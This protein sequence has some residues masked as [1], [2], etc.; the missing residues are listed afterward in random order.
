MATEGPF[1]HEQKRFTLRHLRDLGFGKTSYEDMML[2]EI[3]ELLG[4]ISAAAEA[5][6]GRVVNY[7]GIFD[8]SLINVLW[9]IVG[10]ERYRRGDQYLKRLLRLIETIFRSGNAVGACTPIPLIVFKMFPKLRKYFGTRNDLVKE[11][12]EY[13]EVKTGLLFTPYSTYLNIFFEVRYHRTRKNI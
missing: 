6:P 3:Q 4:E 1:W 8:I 12:I 2:D 13:F 5:D 9:S 10:G 7:K 11:I